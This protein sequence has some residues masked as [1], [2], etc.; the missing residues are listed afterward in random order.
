MSNVIIVKAKVLESSEE[1]IETAKTYDLGNIASNKEWQI[2][3]ISI[4]AG[5]IYMI[6]EYE[7][8]KCILVMMDGEEI[9]AYEN[10]FRITKKWQEADFELL[11]RYSTQ[12]EVE[13]EE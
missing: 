12:A 6:R 10:F 9:I 1:Q 2:R 4:L 11:E 7:Q 3:R 13:D 8:N 5:Q